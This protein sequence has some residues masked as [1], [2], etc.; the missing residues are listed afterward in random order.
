MSTALYLGTQGWSYKDWLGTFYPEGLS[1]SKFLEWYSSVFDAV[2]IDSTFYGTP[3]RS[4]VRAWAEITPPDFRFTAKVPRTITHDNH[5]I[6]SGQDMEEFLSIMTAMEEKLGAILIQ[7][8]P[9]YTADEFDGFQ[10]FVSNLPDTIR[11]AV[12]FRHRSWLQPDTFALLREKG[13]AS[14]MIDLP[15]MP[16]HDEVCADFLYVRW[17]GDRKQIQRMHEVQI[18]RTADLDAWSM[19]LDRHFQTARAMF[20]FVNNHYSGHSPSDV[21]QLRSRFGIVDEHPS[22]VPAVQ[23]AL[24]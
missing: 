12:E 7:L 10:S 9:D 20:G 23:G 21:R 13:M 24:F 19:R 22:A 4:R 15:Y 17:L 18:D 16:R 11:F 6:D 5:L 8:P 14:A 2:E 1:P 3:S